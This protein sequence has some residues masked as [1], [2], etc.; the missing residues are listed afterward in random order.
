MAAAFELGLR[1]SKDFA[2]QDPQVKGS[3]DAYDI[4]YPDLCKKNHEEFWILHLNHGHKLISKEC[5]SRGGIASTLVD[6]KLMMKGAVDK[7]SSG[8]ILIHNHPSG[9]VF[10]SVQDNQLTQR[11]KQACQILDIKLLDHL[12]FTTNGYYSYNDEGKL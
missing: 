10:P 8:I 11:V 6:I 5:L 2:R 12:I 7:V 4:I 3:K 9:N 1:C